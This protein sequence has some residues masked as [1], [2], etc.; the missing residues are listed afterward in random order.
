MN[1]NASLFCFNFFFTDTCPSGWT[2]FDGQCY[3]FVD[4]SPTWDEA[5]NEC[6]STGGNGGTLASI[7]NKA[8]NDFFLTI[9]TKYSMVGGHQL[10]DGTW[11]WTDGS[12]WS[13]TNWAP[14]EPNN[15]NERWLWMIGPNAG[16]RAGKW[17]D[18][19]QSGTAGTYGYICQKLPCFPVPPFKC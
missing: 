16:G 9:A 11:T 15:P 14:G 1:N 10:T 4:K 6:Q 7:T 13:F 2:E 3:K 18:G 8:T 5:L 19:S 17:Y 12:P